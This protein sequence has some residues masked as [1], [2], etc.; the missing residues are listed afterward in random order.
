M[1]KFTAG[2]YKQ[3]Q[4]YKSFTPSVV[5]CH[6]AWEN[7]QIDLLIA[8]AMQLLGE[9]NA[10]A[11]LIP[12]VDFFIQMKVAKEARDSNLIEGTKTEIDDVVLPEEEINPEKRDDW[13]E[14]QNYIKA[15]NFAIAQLPELPLCIRLLKSAHKILLS[16]VRG[17]YKAP[18]EIRRSQNWIG[19]SSPSDAFFVPPSAEEVPDI[20]S[21][22]EKFWHNQSLQIPILI[23]I[24]ITHYQFETIHPFLDG[25]GRCGRLLIVLQL[26]DAQILNKPV[27]YM[28]TFFEKH[29]TS[30]Y[31][32]LAM[33]RKSNDLEQWIAFFLSGIV[34]TAQHGIETFRGII[35]LRQEYDEKILTLGSRAKS[36]HKLLQFMFTQPIVNAKRAT[37]ELGM[38]FSSTSLLLKSLTELGVLKETTGHT[39]NRL[40]V[41][42]K[43]LNLFRS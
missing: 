35:S 32:S 38:A 3:Q 10:Y 28:S 2:E 39:R 25:N 13:D 18:G 14:V 12:D 15:M 26:I 40:F 27:L 33:V 20:L 36:A 8:R 43:Y 17:K 34:D 7:P 42:E 41:L 30:Y 22:L 37:K 24:A 5:N 29:R 9:L 11:E 1:K 31:D 6:F 23:K 21:D 4:E 19:G 16:G